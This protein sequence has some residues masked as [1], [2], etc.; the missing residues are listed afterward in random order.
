MMRR[1]LLLTILVLVTLDVSL[2]GVPGAFVFDPAE[3]IDVTHVA[4][5]RPATQV[6][7]LPDLRG[8]AFVRRLVDLPH[9]MPEASEVVVLVRPGARCLPRAICASSP[10][11]AEDPH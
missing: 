6:G 4:R 3:S 5:G 8:G 10:P 7:T 11:S 9:R 1:A 2:P